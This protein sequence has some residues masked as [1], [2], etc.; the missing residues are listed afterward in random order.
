MI[1]PEFWEIQLSSHVAYMEGKDDNLID[2]VADTLT[3][4]N[5]TLTSIKEEGIKVDVSPN[6]RQ[7]VNTVANAL[8]VSTSVYTGSKLA[9]MAP[10]LAGKATIIAGTVL[11]TVASK[12]IIEEVGKNN[13][14]PTKNCSSSDDPESPKS[15]ES[16]TNF[17]WTINSPNE[18]NIL[19]LSTGPGP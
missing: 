7:I 16:P 5:K 9:E 18:S 14:F 15:P 10:T 3:E 11:A 6:V 19:D 17:D 8:T 12:T 4:V 13:I 2:A 1:N